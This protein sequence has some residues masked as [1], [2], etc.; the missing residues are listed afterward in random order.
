[1]TG[2][3]NHADSGCVFTGVN[4]GAEVVAVED[5]IGNDVGWGLGVLLIGVG[6]ALAVG[7][8]RV[9]TASL[10]QAVTAAARIN[11]KIVT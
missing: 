2:I 1:M 8:V 10:V 7:L 9:I 3:S 5:G 6:V 11:C 4:V